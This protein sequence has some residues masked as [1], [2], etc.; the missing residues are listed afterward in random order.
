MTDPEPNIPKNTIGRAALLR[1]HRRQGASFEITFAPRPSISTTISRPATPH[2]RDYAP[3]QLTEN[4][5][6]TLVEPD[7]VD[8]IDISSSR[9]SSP[10]SN[11]SS[12]RATS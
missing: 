4:S 10:I 9:S 7:F 3:S 5:I 6:I 12:E 1:E 8:T 11:D 2:A